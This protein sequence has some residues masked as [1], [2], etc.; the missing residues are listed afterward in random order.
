ML[1]PDDLEELNREFDSWHPQQILRWAVEEYGQEL[2]VVTSFQPAGIATLHMLHEL[3]TPVTVLTLD[4]GLLFPETYALIDEVEALFNLN[5]VR[6]RP[7][8]TVQEQEW[9]YGAELW[10]RTPDTCCQLRKV[11]PLGPALAGFDA[12]ITGLRRDQP[13]RA[14]T[15]IIGWDS[16]YQKVKLSPCANW[17]EEM[18]W[19]YIDVHELPYNPLHDQGYPSI[20]CNTLTCTQPVFDNEDSRSGRWINHTNKTECGIHMTLPALDLHGGC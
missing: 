13:G 1:R 16:K 3:H 20:G 8:L 11:T 6:V 19:M 18:I 7:A 2:A 10:K 5:L 15:P 14:K 4:T 12:W 17:T 9:E